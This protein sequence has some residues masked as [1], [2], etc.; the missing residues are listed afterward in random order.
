MTQPQTQ[1]V[2][3]SD[4]AAAELMTGAIKSGNLD[5]LHKLLFTDCANPDAR[6][7]GRPMLHFAA[8]LE[9]D[10]AVSLLLQAGADVHQ[11]DSEGHSALRR[12]IMVGDVV[13][14]KKL[15]EAGADP[16]ASVYLRE[17]GVDVSDA[18]LSR[19]HGV[20]VAS[21]VF[22]VVDRFD[23]NRW[24]REGNYPALKDLLEDET[25]PDTFDRYGL[26]AL[27]E[28]ADMGNVPALALLLKYKA[29]PNLRMKDGTT[30]MH[31]AAAAETPSAVAKLYAAG[32]EMG[33]K[34]SAGLTP[35]DHALRKGNSEVIAAVRKFMI[36]EE[37]IFVTSATQLSKPVAAPK[38][39]KFSKPKTPEA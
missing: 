13:S 19:E 24:V 6:H 14:V 26:T 36:E 9:Q 31:H 39:A 17:R 10:K 11:L 2:K 25:P 29:D 12:A 3:M 16:T 21:A 15:V 33:V 1:A 23:V 22:S 27:V 37:K 5:A 20:E 38:T 30:A 28:A 4:K 18:D 7:N 35:L 32:A 8:A 34:D